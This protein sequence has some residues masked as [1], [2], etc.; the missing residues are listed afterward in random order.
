LLKL[1]LLLLTL[2]FFLLLALLLLGLQL[3]STHRKALWAHWFHHL[4]RTWIGQ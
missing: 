1:S 3:I 4:S 2:G